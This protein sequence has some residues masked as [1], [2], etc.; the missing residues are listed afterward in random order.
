MSRDP[1]TCVLA[2]GQFRRGVLR[3]VRLAG[4]ERLLHA[5]GSSDRTG[6]LLADLEAEHLKLR[7]V[8]ELHTDIGDRVHGRVIRVRRVDRLQRDVRER[9]G[10]GLVRRVA[11]QGGPAARRDSRPA[12][13][14]GDQRVV[15]LRGGPGHE[16]P[17]GV[18]VGGALRDAQRPRPQPP[19]GLRLVH[20]REG[21][22][23]VG[24]DGRVGGGDG[25][26]RDRGVVPHRA[27]A[28]AV[29]GQQ[30]V[31]AV[32]GGAGLA[33]L[34]DQVDVEV[35]RGLKRRR[36]ELRLP[37]LVE[38]LAAER[39]DDRVQR[40]H[41]VAPARQAAQADPGY[42]SWLVELGRIA[43]HLRPGWVR[44]H[45][46]PG[47]L[48]QVLAVV[49]HRRLAVERDRVQAALVGQGLGDR[50]EQV[51]GVVARVLRDVLRGPVVQPAVLREQRRLVRPDHDHVERVAVR[52]HVLLDRR[53]QVTLGVRGE[54]DLDSRV[55]LLE[56]RRGQRDHLAGD[57]RVGHHGHGYRAGS[58]TA[59]SATATGTRAAAGTGGQRRQGGYAAHCPERAELDWG[60]AHKRTSATNE[61]VV[62]G[63]TGQDPWWGL[64][65]CR[66]C[67]LEYA[68]L[69]VSPLK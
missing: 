35:S 10:L 67:T 62:T 46:D 61:D 64:L 32:V 2:A 29:E 58:A 42:L 1:V 60:I 26:C 44:R 19:R 43:R 34:A 23:G 57:Q 25:G 41:V 50:R 6:D 16:L 65:Y 69:S 28:L 13:L 53:P 4:R 31:E 63:G 56:I 68:H 36:G 47:R 20:G 54:L 52:G 51:A 15:V 39:V 8:D 3:G 9:T 18:R 66:D 49:Q 5:L 59:A 14:A 37:L 38:P 27:L 45:R 17:G 12:V 24:E 55:L 7:D 11:V 48:E 33:V 30:L 21:V 40:G 22:G